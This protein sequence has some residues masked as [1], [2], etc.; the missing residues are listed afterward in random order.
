[1]MSGVTYFVIVDG[2]DSAES[3]SYTLDVVQN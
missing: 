2:Y 1:L 3:G